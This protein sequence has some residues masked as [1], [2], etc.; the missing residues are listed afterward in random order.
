MMAGR[1]WIV[2]GGEVGRRLLG[3][4]L[5]LA[6]LLSSRATAAY[7]QAPANVAPGC[8]PGDASFDVQDGKSGGQETG[9]PAGKAVV[10][11]IGY[12]NSAA[13][14]ATPTIR[15]GMDGA[16]I[17]ATRHNSYVRE[18]IETGTHHYC[19]QWQ[20]RLKSLSSQTSLYN[21]VADP[22]RVYYLRA[23]AHSD[24]GVG[25]ITFPY[26]AL[27]PVSEDEGRLLLS[28]SVPAVSTAK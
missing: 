8:G 28:E 15:V 24:A 9:P 3:P 21:F 11:I 18:E 1:S 27:E 23:A 20:S 14:K 26:L 17:G 12:F 7:A 10:Y 16:W 19:A 25:G 2:G 22:G 13:T 5:L 6:A 4:G